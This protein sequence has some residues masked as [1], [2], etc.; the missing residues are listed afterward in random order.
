MK[1]LLE[2]WGLPPT[3]IAVFLEEEISEED[4]KDGLPEDLIRRLIT[5]EGPRLRF[6][7]KLTEWKKSAPTSQAPLSPAPPSPVPSTSF[8]SSG[9]SLQF[10]VIQESVEVEEVETQA[11]KSSL[12]KGP[13]VNDLH[14]YLQS[15]I[16]GQLLLSYYDKH[17]CLD[18][19]ERDCLAERAILF[20]LQGHYDRSLTRSH[21]SNLAD[22]IVE[23]FPNESAI[24]YYHVINKKVKGTSK[25]VGTKLADRTFVQ[26]KLR[27]K[28]YGVR[29]KLMKCGL[30]TKRSVYAEQI[31]DDDP[32]DECF[33]GTDKDNEDFLWLLSNDDPWTDV[34]AKWSNTWAQRKRKRDRVATIFSYV[35]LFPA[36]NRVD[37]WELLV[38]DAELEHPEFAFSNLEWSPF[39]E[40]LNKLLTKVDPTLKISATSEDEKC[41]ET[42][43]RMAT[44][45]KVR[46]VP[47]AQGA[48]TNANAWRPTRTETQQGFFLVVQRIP[49]IKEKLSQRRT[50]A[51][52]Y[53]YTVQ[54]VPV[55]LMQD[56][57][58]KQCFICFDT[59]RWEVSCVKEAVLVTFKILFALDLSYPPE[60]RHLWLFLQKT[61]FKMDTD[62]DFDNDKGLRSYLASYLKQYQVLASK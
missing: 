14:K 26:G 50:R 16:D 15:F 5:K 48:P 34:R 6:Q 57:L 29:T 38:A 13:A 32:D 28:W 30:L 46:T 62:V 4:L 20:A 39:L 31:S 12:L 59:F 42:L 61:L 21:F 53:N 43:R 51:E 58:V 24:T 8:S 10:S 33:D 19:N 25:K 37:G 18:S 45:F 35:S 3:V 1:R 56:D 44:L 9:D 27:F 54:P 55:I 36:L 49:E 17:D 23:I 52:R 41:V 2:S 7:K 40:C 47:K 11:A 60:S 22:C